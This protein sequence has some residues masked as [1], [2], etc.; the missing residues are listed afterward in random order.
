MEPIITKPVLGKLL[1]IVTFLLP[2]LIVLEV[3]PT[4]KAIIYFVL[5]LIGGCSYCLGFTGGV[6][7]AVYS[8]LI[9]LGLLFFV[10]GAANS[11]SPFQ[12]ISLYLLTGIIGGQVATRCRNFLHSASRTSNCRADVTCGVMSDLMQEVKQAKME[13]DIA[14]QNFE[15]A[16]EEIV[17]VAVVKLNDALEKYDR[18][19]DM[20]DQI[21]ERQ[22]LT[23]KV[24][25]FSRG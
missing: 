5:A 3:I 9:T 19:M 12:V 2:C 21:W 22:G 18:L 20:L 7:S 14:R 10:P 17:D 24:N 16:E 15:Y 13:L 23:V 25:T 11:Y 6:C 8:S 4:E 1:I